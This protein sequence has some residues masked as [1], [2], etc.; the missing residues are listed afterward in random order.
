M[1]CGHCVQAVTTE[2]S[3]LAG[4][5]EVAVDLQ[6]KTVA[7]TGS[8]QQAEVADAVAEAGYTLVG[9]A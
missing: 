9:R 4:V 7:V 8:V 5:D 1:T 3:A 6:A 2:V